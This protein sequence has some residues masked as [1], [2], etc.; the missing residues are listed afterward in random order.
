MKKVSDPE[1]K[2]VLLEITDELERAA[3][4]LGRRIPTALSSEVSRE[5]IESALRS[6]DSHIAKGEHR[7]FEHGKLIETLKDRNI[8]YHLLLNLETGLHLLRTTR[9]RLVKELEHD[10][11]LRRLR[12]GCGRPRRRGDRVTSLGGTGGS[13]HDLLRT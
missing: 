12:G 2:R 9:V 4:F 6:V 11:S 13:H 1:A 10:R 7:L 5:H 8:A 3:A